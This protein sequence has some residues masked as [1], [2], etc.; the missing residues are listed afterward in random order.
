MTCLV[1]PH[2]LK[3][4]MPGTWGGCMTRTNGGRMLRS[5]VSKRSLHS[6]CCRITADD[7]RNHFYRAFITGA[8]SF[9]FL[10]MLVLFAG[11]SHAQEVTG[12]IVGTVVDQSGAAL[13]NAKV[14]AT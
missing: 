9:C 3:R 5:Q 10:S 4:A 13:K 14:T 6:S 7:G 1:N 2:D 11:I 12:A 8:L